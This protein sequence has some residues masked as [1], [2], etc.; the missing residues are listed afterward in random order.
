MSHNLARSLHGLL[1]NNLYL[2]D[3]NP[4][5]LDS[6]PCML[7]SNPFKLDKRH[8]ILDNNTHIL[9]NSTHILDSRILNNPVKASNMQGNQHS[10]VVTRFQLATNKFQVSVATRFLAYSSKHEQCRSPPH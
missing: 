3:N 6:N 9:G 10:L 8:I 7:D 5:L 2:L 4:F 1:D